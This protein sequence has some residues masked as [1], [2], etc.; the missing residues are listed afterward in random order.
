MIVDAGIIAYPT[1]GYKGVTVDLGIISDPRIACNDSCAMDSGVVGDVGVILDYGSKINS[2]V[3]GDCSGTAN[4]G[5]TINLGVA[6]NESVFVNLGILIDHS[7]IANPGEAIVGEVPFALD[8]A[9]EIARFD[10]VGATYLGYAFL[11]LDL[12]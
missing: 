9:T 2:S 8:I 6:M 4:L 11:W 10:D 1:T 3:I 5:G 7:F 12:V